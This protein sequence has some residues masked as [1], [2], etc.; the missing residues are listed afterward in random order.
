MEPEVITST[1]NLSTTLIY[2]M[3]TTGDAVIYH[4]QIT[5]ADVLTIA[6]I[7]ALVILEIWREV[8]KVAKGGSN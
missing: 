8:R 6:P 4:R 2:T 7:W 3:P 5:F 1:E